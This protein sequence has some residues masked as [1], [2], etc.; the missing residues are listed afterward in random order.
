VL[1]FETEQLLA[2]FADEKEADSLAFGVAS[3]MEQH[4]GQVGGQGV[5]ARLAFVEHF[6]CGAVVGA[7]TGFAH[8]AVDGRQQPF[9]A[10]GVDH[11]ARR[12]SWP[13]LRAALGH[14]VAGMTIIGRSVPD[15]F[16]LF[17]C[18]GQIKRGRN[19]LR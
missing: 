2:A 13:A 14:R 7:M 4:A 19:S 12:P 8:F 10:V 1:L 6:Q 18:D 16:D 5:E 15:S 9:Q 11:V 17:E 3:Q